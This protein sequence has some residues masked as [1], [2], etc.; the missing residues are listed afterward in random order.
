MARTRTAEPSLDK[1]FGRSGRPIYAVDAERR[2]VYC[3]PAL[4][5]WVGLDAKQI[6]GRYVEYHSEPTSDGSAASDTVGPL[7]GLCPPPHALAGQVSDATV[8]CIARDGRLV[9]RHADFVPLEMPVNRAGTGDGRSQITSKRGGVIVLLADRDLSPQELVAKLSGEPSADELHRAIRRFRH[10][11]TAEYATASLLGNSSAMRKVRAQVLAAAASGA[12][13]LIH[14]SQGTG[15][16]HAARAIHYHA[17]DDA[18]VTLVPVDCDVLSEDRWRRILDSCRGPA[19][20]NAKQRPTLL[21]HNLECMPASYQAQLSEA[22]RRNLIA[23]R[24]I[25]TRTDRPHAARNMSLAGNSGDAG[26]VTA[27][28]PQTVPTPPV[29]ADLLDELSTLTI[30]LPRLVER[31]EDLPILAQC[32]LEACNR[33]SEKQVGFVRPDAI[34]L[35]TLHSWPGELNELREVISAAYQTTKTHE[36]TAGDL[37]AVIYHAAKAASLPQRQPPE[38][39]VL[40]E[41]LAR[42]EKEVVLRALTQAR[43]NKTEAAALLGMTRPRL[44]RRL[45]QLGLVVEASAEPIVF[46]LDSAEQEQ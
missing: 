11:Q 30:R 37:P 35:L 8:S 3:N 24:V 14:G 10:A 31:I 28:D 25:A 20:G 33:N 34:D 46:E 39:I 26:V 40:D 1:L 13:V 9:H 7:T 23:A 22:I 5:A 45:V 16:T 29:A 2:I 27:I 19:A 43:G 38:R 17:A 12:N 42:I 44:Y 41:L 21:L 15:R 6:A 18:P 32:F 36:I 4:A